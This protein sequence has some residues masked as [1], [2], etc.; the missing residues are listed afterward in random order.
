V[1]LD[2]NA[3]FLPVRTGFPLES[4]VARLLPGARLVVASSTVRELAALEARRTPLALG[5]RAYASRFPVVDTEREGDAG[6]LDAAVRERAT[7][8]TADRELQERVRAAGL[9]VLVPRDRHRL[10]L[11]RPV[12]TAPRAHGSAR[13]AD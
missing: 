5:A 12:R 9:A 3:L 4:E 11:Q 1:V 10:E 2:T 6:V 13:D 7:V 8:L